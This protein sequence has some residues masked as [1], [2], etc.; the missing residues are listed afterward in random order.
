MDAALDDTVS[1]RQRAQRLEDVHVYTSQPVFKYAKQVDLAWSRD[2]MIE[3]WRSIMS[4]MNMQG[5][6][7]PNEA[8]QACNKCIL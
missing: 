2:I 8:R 7:L 1:P 5:E 6:R 4:M 3:L